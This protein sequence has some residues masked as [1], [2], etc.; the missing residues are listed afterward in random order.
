MPGVAWSPA[1]STLSPRLEAMHAVIPALRAGVAAV[2]LDPPLGIPMLGYG[3]RMEVARSV[4]DPLFARAIFLSGASDL[5]LVEAD[6]C[7]LAPPQADAIRSRIAARS[8]VPSE[9]ILLGCIHTHSGPEPGFAA[10]LGRTSPPPYTG[11][12]FGRIEEAALC[13]QSN[14]AP[15]RLGI[16]R[17]EARIGLNRRRADGPV[18]TTVRIVRI[19]RDDG[20]PLAILYLHGCHPTVLG[21]ENLAYSAD[22]PGVASRTIEAAFPGATAVFA[23][24]AH[25][26]IDPRT[27]GLLDL[28]VEGQSR[29][30]GFEA[31]EALGR[32][33][34]E[35]VARA[36]GSIQTEERVELAAASRRL[37]IP[38][39]GSEHGE[40]AYEARLARG[41]L[42]RLLRE[43]TR[44]FPAEEARERSARVRLYLRDRTAPRFAGGRRPQVEVQLLR[45]GELWLLGVPAEPTVDVGWDWSRRMGDAPAALVS[46]ANGWLR[47]LPHPANFSEPDGDRAYEVLMSTLVPDAAARILDAGERLRERLAPA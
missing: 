3:A 15:A 29:G 31:M 13:A 9:R 42:F 41:E 34:G 24:S 2:P 14:A 39:H 21:H 40:V 10:W 28:A 37:S 7:L 27:R 38:V 32:E 12:L 17:S 16:G 45:L 35:A 4:H 47:Y 43:R 8:G 33:V 36:A 5:L 44:G 20:S 1:A 46:I 18:D 23:L 22:W 11:G 26:D 25:A 19:D 6:L 30:A